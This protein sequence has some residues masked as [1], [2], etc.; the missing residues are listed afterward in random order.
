MRGG[1]VGGEGDDGDEFICERDDQRSLARSFARLLVR[2]EKLM[3]LIERH[4]RA[5][6]SFFLCLLHKKNFLE[7]NWD[8]ARFPQIIMV[9][10]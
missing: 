2:E 6:L 4:E 5:V 10:N 1:G 3:R 9:S 7:S 8:L